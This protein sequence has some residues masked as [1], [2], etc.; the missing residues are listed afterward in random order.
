MPE[1]GLNAN[2]M[3]LNPGGKQPV[4]RDGFFYRYITIFLII[5]HLKGNPKSKSA[6]SI[7]Y[8]SKIKH[9]RLM[10]GQ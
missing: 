5:T 6:F 7:D 2:A 1:D 9:F 8:V 3:N 4:M 10:I